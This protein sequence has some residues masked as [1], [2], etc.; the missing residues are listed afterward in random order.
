MRVYNNFFKEECSMCYLS[1]SYLH[2]VLYI[3]MA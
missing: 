2:S 3:H 1:L